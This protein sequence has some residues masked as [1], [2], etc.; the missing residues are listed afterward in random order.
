MYGACGETPTATSSVSS[1][2]VRFS[3]NCRARVLGIVGEHLEI[4]RCAQAE[5][6]GGGRA[7]AGEAVVGRG[8]DPGAQRVGDAAGGRS[9][10]CPPAEAALALDMRPEPRPERSAVAE[11]R[12]DRV[13]EMRVRVDEARAGSRRRCGGARHGPAPPRRSGR[14]P[15]A[16]ARPRS[17]ARRRAAPSR[18][19]TLRSRR[20]G[21]GSSARVQSAGRAERRAR[22]TAR[23]GRSAGPSRRRSSPGRLPAA[24]RRCRRR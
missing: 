5:L 20:A 14:P 7:G 18:P 8:R 1:T 9:R 12:V 16:R 19:E 15:S 3:S 6:G 10:P 23:R 11:A 22:S 21:G 2:S 13:L 17:A 24:P 4:D